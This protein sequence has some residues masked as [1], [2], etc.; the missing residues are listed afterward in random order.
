MKRCVVCFILCSLLLAAAACRRDLV[1][2]SVLEGLHKPVIRGLAPARVQFNGSDFGLSV[3]LS[4]EDPQYVLYVNGHRIG[5]ARP[6]YWGGSVFFRI[7]KELAGDLL[8]S[9][10]GGATLSVRVTGIGE[11]YD[12]SDDFDRYRDYVSEPFPLAVERGTTQFTTVGPLFP[13]WTHSSMPLIRC[14]AAGNLYLTWLE[15]LDDVDQAFFCF[16]T[17]EGRSWSQVLNI[18]RT[19]APV[20]EPDLAVDGAGHFYM[21]WMANQGQRSEVFF[22]RSTDNGA[23]WHQPKRLSPEGVDAG[24]PALAVDDRG[25]VFLAW[26]QSVNGGL[27]VMLASSHDLGASWSQRSFPVTAVMDNWKPLLSTRAGGRIDLFLGRSGDPGTV[28]IHSSSEY[29]AT[30]TMRTIAFGECF[31]SSERH[32]V[33]YGEGE[34]LCLYWSG[35]SYAGHTFSLWNYLLTRS[36]AGAWSAI[37]DLKDWSPT[38]ESKFSVVP[39]GERVDAVLGTAC[40]LYLLRSV[41]GA[42][43]WGVPETV[44][45]ADGESTGHFPDAVLHPSGK[46]YLVFVRKDAAGK[47]SLHLTAFD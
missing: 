44:A 45:G 47:C 17:D 7:S 2:D 28:D 26:Q 24:W 3:L 40:C 39:Q 18:S 9:S 35:V 4:T 10:A 33:R 11:E 30:W 37:Q 16:S 41:D 43:T 32:A 6:G 13:E 42:K 19:S 34:Q 8:G 38:S 46:T 25:G 29:G 12:I 27:A 20:Y 15:A 21:A 36:S 31:P 5:M 22:S 23:T 14:D 1:P